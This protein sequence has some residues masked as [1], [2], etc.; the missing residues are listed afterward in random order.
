MVEWWETL[1][2]YLFIYLFYLVRCISRAHLSRVQYYSA[3]R[4]RA[5]TI[6]ITAT[7]TTPIPIPIPIPIPTPIP[8]PA[9]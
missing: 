1:L 9:M 7:T 6:T 8:I 2:A 4:S 5:I 3:V